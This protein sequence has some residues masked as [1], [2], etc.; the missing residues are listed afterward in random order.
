MNENATRYI[1]ATIPTPNLKA[2]VDKSANQELTEH[3]KNFSEKYGVTD[4]LNGNQLISE[5]K[6]TNERYISLLA[7]EFE[8]KKSAKAFSKKH[9]S[10]TGDIDVSKIYRYKLDDTIFRKMM[11]IPKGKS[12]G[13]MMLLD[14]S[15]SM[16]DSMSGAIEQILVLAMFCRKVNIPFD[17]YGFTKNLKN[18]SSSDNIFS[19]NDGDLSMRSVTLRHM[20]SSNMKSA[21]FTEALKNLLS[22]KYVYDKMTWSEAYLP[23]G[24]RLTNT[25]LN[26]ALIAV[27][28]LI[29]D[30]KLKNN[31]D[32]VNLVVVH[33]GD[34]DETRQI[35]AKGYFYPQSQKIF[36]KD[37]KSKI[38]IELEQSHRGVTVGLMQYITKTTGAKVMGFFIAGNKNSKTRGTI[39]MYYTNEKG[40]SFSSRTN[41]IG[42][43]Y[44]D[45]FELSN[46]MKK[47]RKEKYIQSYTTGYEKL[48]IIP[49]GSDLNI[50]DEEL[51]IDG[52]ITANKLATAFMKVNKNRQ[53]SR[54]MISRFIEA[55]ASH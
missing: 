25:P 34:A 44:G 22:I 54:V 40:K 33:D 50:E 18:T 7:K 14:K 32:L 35:V 37:T 28:P 27:K 1:Y 13:L 29:E 55:I 2:I 15:G 41:H 45:D 53:T 3:F 48:F 8:M 24:E 47:L 11:H 39:R 17:V 30:F 16:H 6:S 10:E 20:I 36:I 51:K 5:F 42:A 19:K 38:Q 9:I 46:L 26:E 21:E 12:H 52:K 43:Y 4:V 49:G 31:L 23:T